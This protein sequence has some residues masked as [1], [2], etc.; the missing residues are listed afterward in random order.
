MV[1]QG[2][3]TNSIV[4][5]IKSIRS[6]RN[7]GV[8][9]GIVTEGKEPIPS[10]SLGL[11]FAEKEKEKV[12]LDTLEESHTPEVFSTPRMTPIQGLDDQVAHHP[13]KTQEEK[14]LEKELP[15]FSN[16][17]GNYHTETRT[18]NEETFKQLHWKKDEEA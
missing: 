5:S 8:N 13:D 11:D 2:A 18:G 7:V 4:R 14:V 1:P 15:V 9:E 6:A 17:A 12:G 3:R 16:T 10:P